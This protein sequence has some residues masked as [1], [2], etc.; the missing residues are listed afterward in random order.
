MGN[1][2]NF[3]ILVFAIW[4]SAVSCAWSGWFCWVIHVMLIQC[5]N[6]QSASH[7]VTLDTAS[8]CPYAHIY[9]IIMMI[10]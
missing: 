6:G 5:S 8:A 7:Y 9:M 1:F 4:G 10:I 3:E 2:D